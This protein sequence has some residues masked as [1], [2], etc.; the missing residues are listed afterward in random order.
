VETNALTKLCCTCKTYKPKEEFYKHSKQ[1][2]GLQPRCKDCHRIYVKNRYY[3]P[4]G[5]EYYK[6]YSSRP[7][8]KESRKDKTL[9]RNFGISLS[10]YN[11]IAETQEFKCACC[12]STDPKHNSGTDKLL[13]DHCH[14]TGRVRAL[15]CNPCNI[16]VGYCEELPERGTMV[17]EYVLKHK[18]K[19]NA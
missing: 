6:E 18:G 12:G 5:Q 3:S 14:T 2:D 1:K 16:M 9:K 17:T 7:E 10:E 4:K 11:S 8:V 19:Q 13:V 15:L